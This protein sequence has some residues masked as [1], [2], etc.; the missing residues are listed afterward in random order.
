MTEEMGEECL[1]LR[2]LM[3]SL[4]AILSLAPHR[5]PI[6][7][8][9]KQHVSRYCQM[10]PQI[11]SYNCSTLRLLQTSTEDPQTHKDPTKKELLLAGHQ[12]TTLFGAH[13]KKLHKSP[14]ALTGEALGVSVEM[15]VP[16][17]SPARL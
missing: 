2:G 5:H 9:D 7:R 14:S 15:P 6:P 11:L 17:A 10:C 16:E 13:P 3:V 4:T 12:P 8:R 1:S